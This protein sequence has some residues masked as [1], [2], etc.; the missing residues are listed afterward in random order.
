MNLTKQKRTTECSSSVAACLVAATV[1]VL[2]V[3][4]AEAS[5]PPD[6]AI[7][8]THT[9]DLDGDGA[10]D[11]IEVSFSGGA[12]C[13][14]RLSVYLSSTGEAHPL[15]FELD[16]GY[17]GGLDLSRPEQFEI[18]KTDGTLP[19]LVM[20]VGIYNGELQPIPQIWTEQ[21]GV[22]THRV[23]VGFTGGRLR[24]RDW[25]ARPSR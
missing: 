11:E 12:H 4:C 21:Y 25:P 10:N 16:G 6:P 24:I 18:R 17:I 23:A 2:S 15:P 7:P 19:E 9:F 14:Y 8:W 13:C 22:R 5:T 20:R 3:A 1:V